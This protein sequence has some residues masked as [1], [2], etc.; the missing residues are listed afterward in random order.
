MLYVTMPMLRNGKRVQYLYQLAG[1]VIGTFHDVHESWDY[2]FGHYS[3][4]KAD[5]IQT[6]HIKIKSSPAYSLP[7]KH[8]IFPLHPM[9]KAETPLQLGSGRKMLKLWKK[10]TKTA[11][12]LNYIAKWSNWAGWKHWFSMW[13]KCLD[14]IN[15]VDTS[16]SLKPT[17]GRHLDRSWR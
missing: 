15:N 9:G 6:S 13:E 4:P 14:Q 8:K 11:F 2:Y 1:R 12:V 5:S 7:G 17:Q 3:T 16:S 10:T